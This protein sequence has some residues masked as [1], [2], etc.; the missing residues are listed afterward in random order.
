MTFVRTDCPSCGE[1]ILLD[2]VN[3]TGYCMYCGSKVEPE[4]ITK[5]TPTVRVVISTVAKK[6]DEYDDKPW[7]ADLSRES[8]F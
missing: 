3:G 7:R 1:A 8:N 6:R 2:T 4:G 5:I